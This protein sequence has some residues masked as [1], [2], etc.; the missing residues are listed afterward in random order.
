MTRSRIL[1]VRG[2]RFLSLIFRGLDI[3]RREYLTSKLQVVNT[4]R[5]HF[6]LSTSKY[7]DGFTLIEILVTIAIISVIFGVIISSASQVQR[8]G[9]DAQRQ[10]DLRSV[11]AA[12]QQHYADWQYYPDSITFGNPISEGGKTYL[13]TAPKDPVNS[14]GNI[15]TY[16]PLTAAGVAGTCSKTQSNYTLRCHK[17]CLFAKLEGSTASI[18]AAS[19]CGSNNVAAPSGNPNYV[20]TQ[21]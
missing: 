6:K 21:P 19:Q 15:Y 1:E 20:I 11:Q 18:N 16:T 17:Y 3:L 13:A 5:S 12:I 4:S 2:E 10:T 7:Q 9:R 8:S 14:G